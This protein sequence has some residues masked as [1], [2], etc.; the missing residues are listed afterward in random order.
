MEIGE[1]LRL[2]HVRQNAK[3]ASSG[4]LFLFA[5]PYMYVH[6]S[7]AQDKYCHKLDFIHTHVLIIDSTVLR[8]L[9]RLRGIMDLISQL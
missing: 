5:L 7:L 3:A 6:V 9:R 4:F 8:S 1:V 2:S